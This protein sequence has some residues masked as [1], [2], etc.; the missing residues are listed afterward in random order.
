MVIEAFVVANPV[1]NCDYV[2]IGVANLRLKSG[3]LGYSMAR[4]KSLVS[5]ELGVQPFR[6][7]SNG[8]PFLKKFSKCF[9]SIRRVAESIQSWT[10]TDLNLTFENYLGVDSSFSE[11]IMEA[12][13]PAYGNSGLPA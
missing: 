6:V 8:G 10:E 2:S 12:D 3:V 13:D 4:R 5:I 7:D 1:L 9:E 11:S